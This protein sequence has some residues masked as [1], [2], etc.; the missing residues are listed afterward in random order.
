MTNPA[1]R[2]LTAG[3]RQAWLGTVRLLTVLP[4]A[5]DAQLDK[6]AGLTFFEYHVLSMLSERPDRSL[7]MSRLA[8]LTSASPSRLSNVA[9]R[10][11][12][13]GLLRREPDPGDGR[14]IRAV[15]TDEGLR[16]VVEAAPAHVGA[17]RDLVIDALT[18]DELRDLHAAQERILAR[19]DPAATTRPEWFT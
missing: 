14:A 3:Q 8:Q 11:E 16:T 17:V 2:W 18:D 1:A 15:L 13:R 5:L 12:A 4:A 19:L 6:D 7:R 10:L 9:K